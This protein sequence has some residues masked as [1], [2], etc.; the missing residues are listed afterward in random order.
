[1]LQQENE[2]LRTRVSELEVINDL[3]R[4]R[5]SELEE[6][7]QQYRQR[8]SAREEEAQRLT[9]EL[10]EA[11]ARSAKLQRTLEQMQQSNG[12]EKEEEG[13]A[14]KRAR[15]GTDSESG[16]HTTSEVDSAKAVDD[17]TGTLS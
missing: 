8:E 6:H 1:M 2:T 4:G 12:E 15:I 7:E 9:A 16:S 14:R 17:G 13:P 3:F 5:V 10:V 11:N